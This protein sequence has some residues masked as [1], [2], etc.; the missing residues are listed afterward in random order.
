MHVSALQKRLLALAALA[1]ENDELEAEIN[2][3]FGEACF[4]IIR[5]LADCSQEMPQNGDLE[6]RIQILEEPTTPKGFT[7]E[8]CRARAARSEEPTLA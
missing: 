6:V 8:K 5:L 4:N 1:R 7:A 2:K 3:F